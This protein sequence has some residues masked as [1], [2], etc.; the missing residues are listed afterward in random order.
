MFSPVQKV[1]LVTGVVVGALLGFLAVS[2]AYDVFDDQPRVANAITR[3]EIHF[4]AEKCPARPNVFKIGRDNLLLDTHDNAD[5]NE[6]R[7]LKR[8][9]EFFSYCKSTQPVISFFYRG[10]TAVSSNVVR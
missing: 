4:T 7:C 9:K 2:S 10:N 1:V 5:K 3:C 8:A 6:A